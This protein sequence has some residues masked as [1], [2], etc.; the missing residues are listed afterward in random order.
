VAALVGSCL[1]LTLMAAPAF[2]AAGVSQPP[3]PYPFVVP[4]DSTGTPASFTVSFTGYPPS[5]G[6]LVEQ[7]DGVSHTVAGYDPNI[8]CDSAT[9]PGAVTSDASGNGTFPANDVNFGFFPFRGASPQSKFNCNSPADP[10]LSNG[11]PN[12][13]NCQVRV[14]TSTSAVTSNDVYFGI[15]LKNAQ[16]NVPETPYAI[17]LPLG[18][19]LLLGGGLGLTIY[20]RRRHAPVAAA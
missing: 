5:T 4:N 14:T 3:P 20:R 7:C 13:T 8:H 16:G 2:A 9:A 18:A 1:A 19:M 17:L 12:F 15:T 11:L 10:P 6:V